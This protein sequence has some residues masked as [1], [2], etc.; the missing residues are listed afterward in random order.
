MPR[1]SGKKVRFLSPRDL[2][3]FWFV[4]FHSLG[5]KQ[6]EAISEYT[7]ARLEGLGHVAELAITSRQLPDGQV[8]VGPAVP[9]LAE[10]CVY[11]SSWFSTGVDMRMLMMIGNMMAD[12]HRYNVSRDET[13]PAQTEK[14]ASEKSKNKVKDL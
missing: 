11:H 13:E 2:F 5:F 1:C 9:T 10:F 4:T 3:A 14:P 8:I 6:I 12:V 7:P